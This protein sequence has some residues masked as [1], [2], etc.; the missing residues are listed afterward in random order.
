M[1]GTHPAQVTQAALVRTDVET[2][3]VFDIQRNDCVAVRKLTHFSEQG[4]VQVARD[5]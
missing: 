1:A 3:S 2:M 5:E 4:L